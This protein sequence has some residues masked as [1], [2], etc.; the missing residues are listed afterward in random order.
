MLRIFLL[1]NLI[2]TFGISVT[3]VTISVLVFSFL[4]TVLTILHFVFTSIFGFCSKLLSFLT[5][6]TEYF[7]VPLINFS[8]YCFMQMG[9]AS[10]PGLQTL[11][12]LTII[13]VNFS[14]LVV[15]VLLK[16]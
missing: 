16:F 4:I 9:S 8:A 15:L 7:M 3:I 13:F 11:F 5:K 10:N 12:S 14:A 6:I 1:S 2:N